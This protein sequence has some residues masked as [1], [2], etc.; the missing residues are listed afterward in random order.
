MMRN[1]FLLSAIT[2]LGNVLDMP[3]VEIGNPTPINSKFKK[4]TKGKRHK[5]QK[6]RAN[7]RK[8][9]RVV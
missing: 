1:S 4:Q 9:K 2:T 8:A 5:S 3:T 6:I 7:R